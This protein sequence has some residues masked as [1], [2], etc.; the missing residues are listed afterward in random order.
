[1]SVNNDFYKFSIGMVQFPRVRSGLKF[2]NK[3]IYTNV[4]TNLNGVTTQDFVRN[5]II[6]TVSFDPIDR[7]QIRSISNAMNIGE[8]GGAFSLT[9]RDPIS[10]SMKTGSF[11]V[12]SFPFSI[13]THTENKEKYI[14]DSVVF[15]E[16]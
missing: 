12:K 7:S 13:D 16:V 4:C 5:Q 6:M 9:Y 3:P 11:I 2:E 14:M 1:M 15:Q 10:G 8:T